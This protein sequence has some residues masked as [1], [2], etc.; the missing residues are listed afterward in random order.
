MLL[1][2][3]VV[4]LHLSVATILTQLA[5]LVSLTA[6]QKV[7]LS[8]GFMV[9]VLAYTM[10]A[11][12]FGLAPQL[13]PPPANEDSAAV[14]AVVDAAA[15]GAADGSGKED[16]DGDEAMG[17]DGDDDDDHASNWDGSRAL[18][19]VLPDIMDVVMDDVV[20]ERAKARSSDTYVSKSRAIEAR[21][22]KSY[23]TFEL[24]AKCTPFLPSDAIHSVCSHA[25]VLLCTAGKSP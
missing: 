25:T 17:Q 3:V 23:D 2:V 12:L 20:G 14:S 1:V 6:T 15:S 22:C 13:M 16:G 5:C 18:A 11:V 19:S 21:T 9:H 4:A 7:C 24:L 8:E 10:H